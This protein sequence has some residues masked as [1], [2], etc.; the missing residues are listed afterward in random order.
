MRCHLPQSFL[1]WHSA[2]SLASDERGRHLFRNGTSPRGGHFIRMPEMAPAVC[3]DGGDD[4]SGVMR[5]LRLVQ[6]NILEHR[7]I[8]MPTM[9]WIRGWSQFACHNMYSIHTTH[10]HCSLSALHLVSCCQERWAIDWFWD[11]LA[12]PRLWQHELR[13]F[14]TVTAVAL[15]LDLMQMVCRLHVT[16]CPVLNLLE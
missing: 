1:V 10:L 2:S 4:G 16:V 3:K 8:R 7:T 5:A 15:G 13:Y 9:P 11:L 12:H 14:K 6:R